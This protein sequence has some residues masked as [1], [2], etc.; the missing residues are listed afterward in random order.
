MLTEIQATWSGCPDTV[1]LRSG[2]NQSVKMKLKQFGVQTLAKVVYRKSD[3]KLFVK[4]L[5]S[6]YQKF[7][8]N[9]NAFVKI[10]KTI[11]FNEF[12]FVG[13]YVSCTH[14]MSY[15][16]CTNNTLVAHTIR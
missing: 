16:S 2:T 15:V 11:N 8:N 4:Y 10:A 9:I 3:V 13:S 1:G 12:L 5:K 6:V 14:N 7:S